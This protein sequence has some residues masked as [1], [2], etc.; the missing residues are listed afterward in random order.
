[1]QLIALDA[2]ACSPGARSNW[3]D[4]KLINTDI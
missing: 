4:Q 3:R 2:A 1:M